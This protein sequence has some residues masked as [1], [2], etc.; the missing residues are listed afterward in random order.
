MQVTGFPFPSLGKGL[1]FPGNCRWASVSTLMAQRSSEWHWPQGRCVRGR[2]TCAGRKPA[3]TVERAAS[4]AEIL[5][6]NRGY[7]VARI[8]AGLTIPS[9]L[10]L[11]NLMTEDAGKCLA[12]GIWQYLPVFCWGLPPD[13]VTLLIFGSLAAVLFVLRTGMVS[14]AMGGG[15]QPGWGRQEKQMAPNPI[16]GTSQASWESWALSGQQLP[17]GWW[18][19][20]PFLSLPNTP[21]ERGQR[22]GCRYLKGW[23][24]LSWSN[25]LFLKHFVLRLYIKW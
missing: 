9:G 25:I 10:G 13:H 1:P 22:E 8:P 6:V 18:G 3:R 20:G 4:P 15:W 2:R 17:P 14:G 23:D 16:P 24:A 21:R 19:Q 7:C 11:T 12:E 5:L